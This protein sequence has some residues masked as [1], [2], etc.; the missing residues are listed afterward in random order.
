MKKI[1]GIVWYNDEGVYRRALA[2]FTDAFNMPSSYED[3]MIGVAKIAKDMK[4]DG[5]VLVRAELDPETFPG[6]CKTRGLNVDAKARGELGNDAA[7]EY[8]RTGKGVIIDI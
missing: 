6:W 3:W 5:W 8:L 4:R 2:I 7:A 1:A